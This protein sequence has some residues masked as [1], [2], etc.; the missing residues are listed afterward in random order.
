MSTKL[1]VTAPKGMK[2]RLGTGTYLLN[3]KPQQE[4]KEGGEE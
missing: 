1:T 2:K 3:V 4:G